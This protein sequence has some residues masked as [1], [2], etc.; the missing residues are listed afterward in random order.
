MKLIDRYIFKELFLP[1]TSGVLAFS[2]ILFGSTV[3]FKLVGDAVKHNIPLTD[4]ALL[5]V[6]KS[7]YIIT[8]SI[9]IAT[10]FSTISIFGRLANDLE[11]IA[12]RS[13]VI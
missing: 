5:I 13:N 1:F 12:L 6:L 4:L 10:L 9:P 7:P 3:L 11:I 8:L 2:T